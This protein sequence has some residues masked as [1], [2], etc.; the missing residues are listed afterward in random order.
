MLVTVEEGVIAAGAG[1]ACLE[2]LAE[3]RV[4]VPV[5]QL[6]LPDHFID[7]GDPALLLK[8]CGLDASGIAA[9][10]RARFPQLIRE[11]RSVKSAA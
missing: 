7:H 5:L 11:V 4:E 9:A 3:Q 10:I 2:S 1:S 8:E 6:G